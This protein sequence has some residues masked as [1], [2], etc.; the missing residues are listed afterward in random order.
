[1][2]TVIRTVISPISYIS[3]CK[4]LFSGESSHERFVKG[5]A[6]GSDYR[7]N[8]AYLQSQIEILSSH[9]LIENALQSFANPVDG[10]RSVSQ[11]L[12]AMDVSLSEKSNVVSVTLRGY[13]RER[14]PLFLNHLIDA[15]LKF[16]RENRQSSS[17]TTFER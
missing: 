4:L 14:L 5:L 10:L 13:D 8:R 6:S 16:L 2:L 17:R 11:I 1:M 12:R 7:N 15:Y 3:S 9:T